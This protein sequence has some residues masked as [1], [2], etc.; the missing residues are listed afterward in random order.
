MGGQYPVTPPGEQLCAAPDAA[1]AVQR[2]S[3]VDVIEE[4]G[5]LR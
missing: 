2:D 5:K 3:D 1:V 4:L